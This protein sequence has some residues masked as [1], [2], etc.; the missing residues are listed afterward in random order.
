MT[1]GISTINKALNLIPKRAESRQVERL[2]DTFVDS[3]VAAALQAV[4]HQILYGRRGTGKT[5]ALRYIET[6]AGTNGD[7]G[8]YID[9][10]QVGSPDGLFLGDETPPTERAARLLVDLIVLVHDAIL[11]AALERDDLLLDESFVQRLDALAV[12][13]SSVRIEGEVEVSSEA[14]TNATAKE[15]VSGSAGLSM[16]SVSLEIGSSGE[17]ASEGRDLQKESRKGVERRNLNFTQ[18]AQ[19]LRALADSISRAR[20]WLLLDEWGAIPLDTQ[21]YLAEFLVR[22]ILPVQRFTVKIAA[23]EQQ[24]RFRE[25]R[26]NGQ[27]I[28]IELGADM[29]ANVDLDE[30]MVFELNEERARSFFRALFFKHVT[31]GVDESERVANVTRQEDLVR[32]AFTDKR[33][34]DELVRAAEGVPRDALN[35]AAKAALNAGAGLISVPHVRQAARAWFQTDKERAFSDNTEAQR[36][37]NWI[38]DNVIRT[39]RARGFLVN[40]RETGSLLIKALFD[41]RVLHVVRRGYSAQDEPGERYDVYVIDYG[42]Y[43][44]LIHTKYEPLGML[45]IGVEDDPSYADVP[46]QDLRAIRRAVLRL[47]DFVAPAV[48]A[49]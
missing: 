28:G 37:L 9:L 6:V 25:R 4:D 30:F 3:G 13:I 31:S 38:I 47:D 32:V 7:L 12:A 14:E 1:N 10:R 24:A 34:F 40:Q 26:S 43:V 5:H 22:T 42:A 48:G 20:I 23:I 35:I 17:R 21:P 15:S 39:K 18:V 36:L 45:S 41:A 2:R 29:A 16:K 44:D 27:F 46:T 33:A 19:A 11:G 8:V 49:S